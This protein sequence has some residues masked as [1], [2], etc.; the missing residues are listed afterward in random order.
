MLSLFILILFSLFVVIKSS[1]YAIHYSTRLAESFCLSKY[2]VGFIIVAIISILP[3]SFI[4]ITSAVKGVP[5]FGLGTLFGSNVADLSFVFVFV[6]L[7]AGRNLKVESKIVKNKPVYLVSMLIPIILGLNGHYSRFEGLALIVV[8]VLFYYLTLKDNK[9]D[10]S[11][12]KTKFKIKDVIFLLI[13]M[14]LILLGSQAIVKFG[15]DLANVLYISPVLIGMFIVGLGTV[16]PELIF[17]IKAARHHQDS[18]ALGDIL[19]TVVADATVVVGIVAL[20]CPFEFNRRIVYVTGTFMVLATFL[21]F[22]FM[23]S[24]KKITKKEAILL[25]VFYLFFVSVELLISQ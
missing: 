23:K 13:S 11:I 7:F 12:K 21:L 2:V 5:A 9:L 18:L 24:G 3:E 14:G 10:V 19:G 8:G 6:I 4:S 1:N 22:Y 17:S 25:F 15:I 20:I 16:L